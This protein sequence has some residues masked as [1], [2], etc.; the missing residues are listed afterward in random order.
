MLGLDMLAPSL[1]HN[2]DLFIYRG[3]NCTMEA[4]FTQPTDSEDPIDRE[5]SAGSVKCSKT[6]NG[7]AQ[8]GSIGKGE[9]AVN[10]MGLTDKKA[11]NIVVEL[12]RSSADKDDQSLISFSL[13]GHKT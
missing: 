1:Q 6:I 12:L 13:W 5:L 2:I 11:E 4:W 9:S 8:L 7:T 10:I 3:C